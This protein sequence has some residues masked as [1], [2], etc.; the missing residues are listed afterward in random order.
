[1]N[2]PLRTDL[3]WGV[4]YVVALGGSGLF[5]KLM[6]KAGGATIPSGEADPGTVIG[7]LEDVIIISF[8]A[9]EA[10]TALAIV[11]TAKGIIRKTK[12]DPGDGSSVANPSYYVL[13]TLANFTWAVAVG[14]LPGG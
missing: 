12:F 8:M 6:L 10:F 1:M 2:G 11:F 3:V 13:G 5:V 14:M 4:A 7:K 9:A